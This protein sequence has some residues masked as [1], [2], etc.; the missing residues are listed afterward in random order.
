MPLPP[1]TPQVI[2]CLRCGW[3]DSRLIR[4]DTLP[5]RRPC[6]EC[7]S[8]TTLRNASPAD[9]ARDKPRRLLG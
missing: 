6:P 1:R 9:K 5:P 8:Q 2:A 4:S 3:R 7:G